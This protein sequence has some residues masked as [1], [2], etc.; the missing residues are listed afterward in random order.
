MFCG[1]APRV[2]TSWASFLVA[3]F[4]GLG[5]LR[6]IRLG[7]S[8]RSVVYSIQSYITCLEAPFESDVAFGAWDSV[9]FHAEGY[10]GGYLPAF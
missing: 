9:S 1:L 2:S 10:M 7:R 6:L 8:G 5:V 4:F 3:P